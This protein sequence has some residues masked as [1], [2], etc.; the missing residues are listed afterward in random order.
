METARQGEGSGRT[1]AKE[2]KGQRD[3]GAHL[4]NT[5]PMGDE[6]TGNRVPALTSGLS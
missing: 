3:G 2:V 6:G 4:G 5:K 1:E